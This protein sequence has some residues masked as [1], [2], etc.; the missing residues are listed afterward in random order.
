MTCYP[1][2]LRLSWI[3]LLYTCDELFQVLGKLKR[4]K[5]G[6]R[7]RILPEFLIYGGSELLYRLLMLME[8]IWK[9]EKVVKDWKDAEIVHISK[10][11]DLKKCDNWRGISLLDLVGKVFARILQDRL[12]LITKKVLPESV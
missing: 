4:G 9:S 7:T 6:G 12:Q 1:D 2:P 11:G 5:A 10:K 3:I 8:D